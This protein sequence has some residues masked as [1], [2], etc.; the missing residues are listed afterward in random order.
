M[1][2]IRS[3]MN[4]N[5]D[6]NNPE[7]IEKFISYLNR[8]QYGDHSITDRSKVWK[9][10]PNGKKYDSVSEF[11]WKYQI[12]KMYIRYFNWQFIGMDEDEKNW[13]FNQFYA[14]PLLLGLLGIY[15]HFKNDRKHALSVLALFFM[16]GLAIILY[17]NQPDPQPRERDYSYVGSFFAFSMW[18]G[19]GYAGIMELLFGSKKT[20]EEK[21]ASKAVSVV[22]FIVLILI[23]PVHMLAKNYDSHSRSGRY[24]AWDYS[25]NMLQSCEPN[26]I[27]FTNGDNDTFPLWYLQEVDSIRT[28]VRIVNLSLLNTGWYI[29]QLR[30]LE[31]RVP[32][33]MSD[34]EIDR[35]GL[36]PWK[37]QTVSLPVPKSVGESYASDFRSSFSDVNIEVPDEISFE[38]KPT[39][40][41]RYGSVLRV[42]DYM[43]LKIIHENQWKKPV[44]FA[45]TVPQKNMISGLK[46][47]LR[48]DGLTEKLTPFNK[49]KASPSNLE[50][51]LV[52]VFNYRG[53]QDPEVYYD[54]NLIGLIQNYRSTFLKV[55]DY[56]AKQ[57]N[58]DKA[59]KLL[60]E[61]ENKI[62]GSVIPW[63][64]NYLSL[65]NDSYSVA[66]GN[67]EIE[68][69]LMV[70]YNDKELMMIGESL[71]HLE[72][73]DKASRVFE[74]LYVANPDNV[75]A[76]SILIG[77]YDK[78]KNFKKG[79][80]YL[81]T[82]LKAHPNDT[83]ARS[84]MQ[85][86]IQRSRV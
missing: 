81:E 56:Y 63:T 18:I 7:T 30:D 72:I 29:K 3:N 24:I 37:K 9:Q 23:A 55:V 10:S 6:E 85:E 65:L 82:W 83:N 71:Y 27:I 76:L 57:K 33:R 61:M 41:T 17:L 2:F 45:V 8:E 68:S 12:D 16:T 42:Q 40:N 15:W 53:L 54:K 60:T 35:M 31:P 74:N 28:D 77:I 46:E 14:I 62:P 26:G 13:S 34:G 21:S 4:P 11:F 49:W 75:R 69:L 58:F 44:Y 47:Y 70:E 64:N 86:F 50:K 67:L 48:W 84:K 78:T 36:M 59:E 66:V 39:M 80:E 43:I 19:L 51:N 5:I 79:I 32:I 73:Y 20:D 1:V 25:Y 38:V 22:V 52:N